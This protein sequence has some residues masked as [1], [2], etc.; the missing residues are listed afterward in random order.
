[1]K[2]HFTVIPTPWLSLVLGRCKR[3]QVGRAT[4]VGAYLWYLSGL[5]R[6]R[7]HLLV[8]ADRV[9]WEMGGSQ[10]TVLRGLTDLARAGLVR[11][12]SRRPRHGSLVTLP[13]DAEIE[14]L[15]EHDEA[16][17]VRGAERYQK[18]LR[19]KHEIV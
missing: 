2:G 10:Q 5:R 19:L 9:V 11:I 1:V 7:R 13:T 4:L 12:E 18:G 17:I 6:R 3:R 15:A 14:R 8:V 16:A